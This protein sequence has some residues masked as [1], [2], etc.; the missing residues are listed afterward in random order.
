MVEHLSNFLQIHIVNKVNPHRPAAAS[1]RM[2]LLFTSY[3]SLAEASS[4]SN[5]AQKGVLARPPSAIY[6]PL[7]YYNSF[8]FPGSTDHPSQLP[9]RS[10]FI[11]IHEY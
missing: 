9:Q 6:S 10:D 2:L 8:T 5:H 7:L 4:T 11:L 1:H 3:L